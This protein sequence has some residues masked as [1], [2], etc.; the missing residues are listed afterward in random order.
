M[1]RS[2]SLC[3]SLLLIS[4]AAGA[5]SPVAASQ[6]SVSFNFVNP[7][8]DPAHYTIT[9]HA[10]GTGHYRS[11]PGTAAA[12]D[13]E[14]HPPLPFDQE[15]HVSAPL[16]TELF[17]EA[18]KAHRFAETCD[19]GKP[20]VAFTGRK[21]FSYKGPDGSGSCT[22]NYARDPQ[23]QHLAGQMMA[24]STTL[25]EGRKLRL[26]YLHDRLGLDAELETL[27]GEHASGGAIELQNIAPELRSIIGDDAVL[28]RARNRA[29]SLLD[30]IP[31]GS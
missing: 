7:A 29:Q 8:L 27:T 28:E 23:L 2:A 20:N 26:L 18:K 4:G 6:P 9:I 21:T 3:L 16:R 14:G 31:P 12:P 1:T 22:F 17:A 10:D 11:E 30:S 13:A 19:T 15:I 25:Q 5:Q 24:V